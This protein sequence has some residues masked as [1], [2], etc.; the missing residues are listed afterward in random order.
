[1]LR[2]PGSR[3]F[4][5]RFHPGD[6]WEASFGIVLQRPLV[7]TLPRF[8]PSVGRVVHAGTEF[9]GDWGEGVSIYLETH[10]GF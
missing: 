2:F 1:M 8:H 3:Q 10:H 5:R 6:G 9:S 4:P 7:S